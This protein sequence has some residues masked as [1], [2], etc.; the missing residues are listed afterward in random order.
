MT[1]QTTKRARA[2]RVRKTGR[3]SP[4]T[5]S[6]FLS[7]ELENVRCFSEKQ[8][9]D[10]SDGYGRPA[11]WTILLG[12]NGTGK[13]M[14]LQ[15]LVGF[16]EIPGGSPA[17]EPERKPP[18]Y[19][20]ETLFKI[21]TILRDPSLRQASSTARFVC[22]DRMDS[23]AVRPAHSVTMTFREYGA[24]YGGF[25]QDESPPICFA[26]GAGRRPGGTILD[27]SGASDPT[28]SLFFDDAR[29]INAEEWLLLLD[30]SA[31]KSSGIQA[32][33]EQR[34][35]MVKDVLIGI[36]PDVTEIRFDPSSGVMPRPKVE[37]KT[38]YGW[39][40]LG[41]LGYGERT[42]IAWVVDLVARMIERYPDSPDPLA[43]P[44]V[45]LVDEIELHL[46]PK[47]QRDLI[48][49]L[50][51]RFP[52]TQFIVTSHSPLI[53]Q[54]AAG[55]N[56]AL[57]KRQGDHVI[58]ENHPET[59]RGWR[60]DQVLTSEL[61][62]L[63]TARPPDLEKLLERR[64]EIL[65]K[66]RLTKAD[67]KELEEINDQIGPIAPGESFDEARKTMDLSERSIELVEKSQGTKT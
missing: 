42:M 54:A 45:V 65:A 23:R 7:L 67:Q 25:L 64:K 66:S 11:R 40:P 44:A 8:T 61:F 12:E 30:Y 5:G 51:E 47:W 43:E 37:L 34:L 2:G 22:D 55:A 9:L 24:D 26:Y 21:D 14:I 27:R 49:Y 38:P 48:G 46:H 59:L 15:L 16:E 57:L 3:S 36:L 31:S 13:T 20:Y 29:L 28:E 62:G 19:I 1:D 39:V 41:Q 35:E 50:T 52:N 6:Y 60:I 4:T 17:L 32:R 33:Q 56:L 63:E 10:L 53:V 58:I 18:R